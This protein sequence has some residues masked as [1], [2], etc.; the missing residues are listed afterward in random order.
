MK[1]NLTRLY[2][3]L[4]L[5]YLSNSQTVTNGESQQEEYRFCV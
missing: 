5:E 2:E 3:E 1:F 4:S